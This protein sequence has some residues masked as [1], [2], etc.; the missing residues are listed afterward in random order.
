MF[1]QDMTRYD[2]LKC[3]KNLQNKKAVTKKQYG[4]R[5]CIQ[6]ERQHVPYFR[7]TGHA[8]K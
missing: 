4:A 2:T 3:N 5:Q 6:P 8:H 1:C 7:S